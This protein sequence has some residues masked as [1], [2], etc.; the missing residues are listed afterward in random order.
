MTNGEQDRKWEELLASHR[1]ESLLGAYEFARETRDHGETVAW[2]V[3]SIIWGGQTLMLGFVLEAIS[4]KPQALLLVLIVS[5]LGIVM[6]FFNNKILT[7]RNTVCHLM[8]SL[9]S[10]IEDRLEMEFKPQCEITAK[11]KLG[12]QTKWYR[13]L[14]SAF[15]IAWILV[16][17]VACFTLL[18]A[19]QI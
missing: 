14:N 18:R 1:V 11:Y 13:I 6:M 8:N 9:C 7:A 19:P 2:E 15:G 4:G 16:F 12:Q 3:A 10:G 5:I 17:L